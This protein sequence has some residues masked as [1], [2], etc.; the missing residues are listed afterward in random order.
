MPPSRLLFETLIEVVFEEPNVAVPL[1]TVW[2]VQ[3]VLVFQAFDP[4]LVSQVAFW[5]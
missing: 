4:G 1:G 5:A 2:G 3:L